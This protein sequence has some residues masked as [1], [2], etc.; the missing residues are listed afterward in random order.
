M[1]RKI[2]FVD[3]EPDVLEG[4]LNALRRESYY[5]LT[6]RSAGQALHVLEQHA[7]DVVVSDERMPG[8]TGT[9]FLA[10]VCRAYPDTVRII[11][12]GHASMEAAVRAINEG[13]IYRFLTK[14]VSAMELTQTIREALELKEML[15]D[16]SPPQGSA[17]GRQALL[18]DLETQHPGIT[19]V[20]RGPDGSVVVSESDEDIEVLMRSMKPQRSSF[21]EEARKHV[22]ARRVRNAGGM[23]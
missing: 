8:M 18:R 10:R 17:R 22:I 19:Q 7:I 4:I 21:S 15:A 6:A 23:G 12:T 14:P 20:Q 16:G 13:E 9:Q 2:L 11:L 3:D 5:V 1:L